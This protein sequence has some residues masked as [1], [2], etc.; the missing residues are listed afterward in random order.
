MMKVVDRRCYMYYKPLPPIYNDNSF[1]AFN[2]C[3]D[4]DV[5]RDEVMLKRAE[6]ADLAMIQRW[7]PSE[8]AHLEEKNGGSV[9]SCSF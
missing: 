4:E 1:C 6:V 9:R 8:R 7:S 3:T 5:C 2:V